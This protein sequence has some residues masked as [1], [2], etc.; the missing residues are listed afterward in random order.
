[1]EHDSDRLYW[2]IGVILI[3]AA[4][5]AIA[6]KVF[7]DLGVKVSNKLTKMLGRV[8][9]DGAGAEGTSMP[10][11]GSAIGIVSLLAASPLAIRARQRL[12]R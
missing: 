1:M 4:L 7:P 5:V 3:G 2:T 10:P 8:N 9:D 6:L 11:A 12:A